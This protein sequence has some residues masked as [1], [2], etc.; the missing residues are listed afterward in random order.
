MRT[1][2][3]NDPQLQILFE[4]CFE[5]LHE[6]PSIAKESV[7]D[8]FICTHEYI[9]IN[10]EG[11]CICECCGEQVN[12]LNFQKEYNFKELQSHVMKK[13][14]PYSRISNFHKKTRYLR[15]HQKLKKQDELLKLMSLIEG[16]NFTPSE[17]LEIFKKY[18]LGRFNKH[19]YWL[20]QL[21][22]PINSVLE[23][24]ILLIYNQLL[25]V[26]PRFKLNKKKFFPFNFVVKGILYIIFCCI[27]NL[28]SV[29]EQLN[30]HIPNYIIEK[31][32]KLNFSVYEQ[33]VMN[34]NFTYLEREMKKI[35][36]PIDFVNSVCELNTRQLR[37]GEEVIEQGR[38]ENTFCM[39][40]PLSEEARIA[41]CL[42]SNNI[43]MRILNPRNNEKMNIVQGI[44]AVDPSA[45]KYTVLNQPPEFNYVGRA[46][47]NNAWSVTKVED[48]CPSESVEGMERVNYKIRKIQEQIH[49]AEKL[50]KQTLK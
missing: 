27:P 45:P 11:F 18:K 1:T 16:K 26:Y 23:T 49:S 19:V 25:E 30:D 34:M 8:E 22:L 13:K 29:C 24:L 9:I 3:H 10:E 37:P 50:Q 39:K 44:A 32:F 35:L 17:L 28:R 14:I 15:G 5:N 33:C 12:D 47:I 46:V 38:I 42:Y 20:T 21:K 4:E 43:P 6:E 7:K 2:Y 40:L 41:N 36:Q 48:V 31:N